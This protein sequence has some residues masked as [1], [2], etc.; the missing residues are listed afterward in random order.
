MHDQDEMFLLAT[1]SEDPI[2]EFLW[3]GEEGTA[4]GAACTWRVPTGVTKISIVCVQ[5]GAPTGGLNTS[6]TEVRRGSSGGTIL[7]R[8][9]NYNHVGTGF[10]GGA[11]NIGYYYTTDETGDIYG[12][13]GGGGAAGYANHGNTGLGGSGGAGGGSTSP[14]QGPGGGGVGLYGQGSSGSNG[15]PG[16]PGGAGSNGQPGNTPSYSYGGEY[17]G[18]EGG[19]WAYFATVQGPGGGGLSY[20]NDVTVTPGEILHLNVRYGGSMSGVG[21]I[22]IMWGGGRS[23]PSNAGNLNTTN[24]PTWNPSD[25]GSSLHLRRRNRGVIVA[26]NGG[27]RTTAVL[28]STGRVWWEVYCE[29]ASGV[30]ARAG[31]GSSGEVISTWPGGSTNSYGWNEDGTVKSNNSTVVSNA[32]FTTSDWLGFVWNG[33]TRVLEFYKNGVLQA[34]TITA[35]AGTW[36]PMVGGQGV[37]ARFVANFG[38][39]PVYDY[40]GATH[41]T[42]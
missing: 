42:T 28:P 16:F 34:N 40:A 24:F 14:G 3:G 29:A 38:P 32:A 19:Q 5:T 35:P 20:I 22:R 7:C 2:G 9:E 4:N 15:S 30:S 27:V 17:G 12:G 36:Y 1:A 11:G 39:C 6:G 25:K 33:A 21:A 8:A 37:G 26:G 18:A 13:G 10:N 23:F 41:I 31:I